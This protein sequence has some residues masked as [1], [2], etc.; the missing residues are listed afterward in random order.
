[1][2]RRINAHTHTYG[3]FH[4]HGYICVSACAY[5][6]GHSYHTAAAGAAGAKATQSVDIPL[7]AL[8][9]PLS[10]PDKDPSQ[11]YDWMYDMTSG[12]WKQ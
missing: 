6:A 1:M 3:C 12:T 11:L 5:I 2:L 4:L 8:P 7:S 9:P 10:Q